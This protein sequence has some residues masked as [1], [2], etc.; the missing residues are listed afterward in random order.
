MWNAEHAK[1]GL[2]EAAKKSHQRQLN[3]QFSILNYHFTSAPILNAW[4]T[5]F[6]TVVLSCSF[7][8]L[9]GFSQTKSKL[10]FELKTNEL[11]LALWTSL[12]RN[13]KSNSGDQSESSNERPPQTLADRFDYAWVFIY[14]NTNWRGWR[15]FHQLSQLSWLTRKS[16]LTSV[17]KDLAKRTAKES[18]AWVNAFSCV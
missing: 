9:S 13:L 1:V 4:R 6:R 14:A 12:D 10:K 17:Q 7:S 18:S 5:D 2:A 15:D 11:K 16:R 3:S 8:W